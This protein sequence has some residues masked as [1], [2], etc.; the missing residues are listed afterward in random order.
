MLRFMVF[1]GGL[2]VIFY[3]GAVALQTGAVLN[4]VRVLLGF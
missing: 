4:A 2:V 1:V 3:F